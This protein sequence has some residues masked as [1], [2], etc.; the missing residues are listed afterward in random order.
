MTN[1]QDKLAGLSPARKAALF[2]SL[3]KKRQEGEAPARIGR[4]A[5]GSPAPLSF[6]QLRLWFLD[7]LTPGDPTYNLPS[8]T[9]IRGPLH[10]PA[11][12]HALAEVA[13]RHDA[14]RTTFALTGGEEPVQVIAPRFSPRLPVIDLRGLAADRRTA[15]LTLW[16]E[17]EASLPFD[18]ERGP[19]LR[20]CAFRQADDELIF[21]AVMHHS[22]SDGWS[23][24]VLM[25]EVGAL[26][27]A[28]LAGRP[29]PLAELPIQYADFAAW[30]RETL[31]GERLAA[32]IETWRRR[33]AEAPP[34]I[35]LPADRPRPPVKT[36]RG[37]GIDLS[38]PPRAAARLATLASRL[39]GT[40]F[41]AL[42]AA[43]NALLGRVSGATDLVV[44]TPIANRRLETSP[45]IG[46][47]VNTLA[48]RSDLSGDPAFE[49]LVARTREVALEAF[50]HQ[51][52]P[53][54]KLVEE[55]RPERD[56]S[57]TPVFQVMCALEN[58]PQE[59][60]P[61]TGNPDGLQL[62]TLAS[63]HTAAK[64]D[65]SMNATEFGEDLYGS[66]TGWSGIFELATVERLGRH[67]TALVAA[68][69][70]TP[71]ERISQL[72][73]LEP[74]EIAALTSGWSTPALPGAA[75][76]FV[77]VPERIAAWAVIDPE[78]PALRGAEG[79][80]SYGELR[81]RSLA[82]AHRLRA[83]GVGP[84][85]RVAVTG[86]RSASTVVAI[87]AVLEAGGAYVP[88]DPA[89][90][91]ERRAA[92]LAEAGCAVWLAAV[93]AEEE[94]RTDRSDEVEGLKLR[95]LAAGRPAPLA[96]VLPENAAYVLFTS[97]ST[98]TPKG[99][100][101]EHRQLVRYVEGA[102]TALGLPQGVP[103]VPGTRYALVST[104][105]AD[106]GHTS[107][108]PSLVTGGCLDVV[109]EAAI[110]DPVAF[111]RHLERCPADVLK[112]VPSHLAALLSGPRPAA[113][114]PRQRLI[115]GGE[116]TAPELARRL[117]ELAPDLAVFN[118][119]GPTE[120]TVGALAGP[121]AVPDGDAPIPLGRPLPGVQ[122]LL[123]GTAGEL[124]PE[125]VVGEIHIG[126]CGVARGYLGRPE[127]TAERFV[128]SPLAEGRLYRT[129]DLARL[130]PSGL[131]WLGR[132]DH[133][134]KIRGFRVEPG[135]VEAA[136]LRLDGVREAVVLVL[137]GSG[138]DDRR[139][140]GYAV[141]QEGAA[142]AAP[143]ATELRSALR[144]TLPEAM[145]PADVVILPRLPLTANGKVDRRALARTAPVVSTEPVRFAAPQGPAEEMLAGI[146]AEVLGDRLGEA[147][148]G[149]HDDFFALGGHSL[150]ATRVISRVREAFAVEVPLRA[151]FEAPTV[152][153]LAVRIGQEGI[154]RIG[155]IGR[156]DPRPSGAGDLPLSFAQQRL[157][158]LDRL[159]PD[160]PFYNVFNPLRLSGALDVAALRRAFRE[161]VLRHEG[162]RTTFPE[163][164]GRP[165][166]VI[167]P[168][169]EFLLPLV[170][171][172]GLTGNEGRSELTGLLRAE[173]LRPFQLARG[174]LF[175]ATLIRHA[176]REHT[177]LVNLH[178][179]ISDGWSMGILFAEI[180]A[181][182][183]AFCQGRPSPLPD[184]PIQYAD[185]AL[186][187]RDLLQG[188]RL[189]AELGYWRQQLAGLPESLELPTDH[190]RPVIDTFRGA[191]RTFTLPVE[192]V[193]ALA[194]LTR[195]RGATRS[196]TMLAAF[197]ALLGR[198]AGQEDLATGAV[199]ANRTRREVEGLIGFFVNTLVLRSNLSPTSGFAALL[200]RV[201]ETA[202]A[203]Y[204]HQDLPFE[205]LVEELQPERS[206]NR[207]PLIQVVFS[208]QNFPRSQAQVEGL[209][210]SVPDDVRV[211]TGTAKF[212][213][214]LFLFED[215]DRLQGALEFNRGIFEEA[216]VQR[217]LGG[218]ENLLTAAAADPEAPLTRL[219][220][221]SAAETHQLVREWNEP[222]T[223]WPATESLAA[224]FGTQARRTPDAIALTCG[225]GA[226]SYGA[227]DR[228]SRVLASR[229]RAQ[230]VG[231]E[232]RVG[233]S[234]ERSLELVVGL[235]G[236][237]QAGGAYVPLD[238]ASPR[239]RLAWMIEDAGIQIVVGTA[240]TTA[241]LPEAVQRILLDTG[242][243]PGEPFPGGDREPAVDGSSL[244]YVIYTSGSTGPPKGALVT[245]GNVSRL[246]A[247][248]AA[249]FGFDGRDVWT[250][251]H[252]YA[253]D[254]SVWEIWGA[255]LY[256]GRLVIVPW[257]VS[258]SPGPFLDL[259]VRER[260]T[261]L[262]QTP[263]AFAQ[264]AQADAERGGVA[265][266][267]RWVI[268]GG[269][270]LD[271]ASLG[272]WFA[273][274]GDAQPRL[275]NMYG[276]T[277]TTVHVTFRPL[278]AAEVRGERRSVIGV[279]IPDL[280]L[281]VMDPWLQPV[282]LGVPGELVVGGA[283][284]ARGYLGRPA[285]TA[286]RFVPD[287][288][289]GIPG[290]RLYRSGDRGRFLSRGG[291]EYWGRI[292]HQVKIRGFRIEPGEIE[293]RLSEHP[294]VLQA[295]VV[296]R[297]DR[298]AGGPGDRRLVAY[299]V[300]REAAVPETADDQVSGWGELFDDIY[301]DETAGS[302]PTFNII[303][304]NST[305]TGEPLPRAD[306]VE[307]LDDTIGRI[308]GLAPHRVLEIGCGTGMILWKI[309]PGA[310]LYTGTDVSARA[311]AYIE[312]RL[313]RV[314]GIDPARIRLV[315]GSAEDLA[316]LEAG[317]FDTAII[318]S[319]AQ[320]FPGADY[321]A[322][323]IARLVELVRPGGAIF[324]GDLRSLPLLEAFHTSL[325]VDQAAPEM[326]I[327][328]LRQ[329]IQIRRLQ[330]NELAI[331]P[332]FFT[333]L[334]HRLPGIGRVEIHAKRGRAHNELT[335]YRYQAVLRLGRPA[336]APEISWLDGT[337]QRLTLPA[338]RQLLT[339]GTP[340]ILGLRN[341]PNA[342]TAEAAAAVRL[343]RADDAAIRTAGELR[344]RAAEAAAGAIDPEELASLAQELGYAIE[345]GW[346]A[347]GEAG[348]FEAVLR[349]AGAAALPALAALLPEPEAGTAA[350]ALGLFTNNPLQGRFARRLAP[351][352]RAFLKDRLPD[353][354]V[355]AAFV[356]LDAFPL[357]ANGKVDRRRLP[358]PEETGDR[359]RPAVAAR[360]ATEATLLEI[361]KSLLG[362]ERI[363]IDDDFFALGGHSLLATQA[364]SRVRTAFGRELPLRT[365]FES[366]TVAQLAAWIGREEAG[367]DI[368]ETGSMG[369]IRPVPREG[370]LPLSFAQERLWFLQ[371]L[372]AR[373]LAYNESAAFRLEG[374]LDAAAFRG[375]LDELLR[376]HE[377]LRTTFPEV[378]GRAVQAIQAAVPF[379]I[380]AVDLSGLPLDR[381][382][383]E[384]RRLARAQAL[385]PFDLARGPLVRGLLVRLGA[386]DHAVLFSFHHIVFDGWSIGLF[387]GELSALYAARL[388]GRPSLLPPLEVQYADFAA[389]QRHR[390]QGETLAQ[391]VAWWREQLAGVA[392]LD[393]P[394]DRPRPALPQAVAGQ[395]ALV[396]SPA[397]TRAL[398]E[399][400]RSRGSTLFMTLLAAFQALLRRTTGQDDIA[401]GT[402]IAGRNRTEI[403]PLIGFFINMLVLRTR[404]A[405]DPRF[406]DLLEAV[407]QTALGA[408]AHQDLPFEKLVEEL[409][410]ARSLQ[411]T[412]LFQ[413]SFQVLNM[414]TAVLDLPGLTLHPFAFA[415]RST[416]FDLSL[417]WTDQG[418]RL[419]GL[420]GYDTDLFDATT[421]ERFLE[422]LHRLLEGAA[423][424]P[425]ARLSDLP[426]L[427]P[428]EQHQLAVEWND[429]AMHLPSEA[430]L[431]ELFEAQARRTPE[432]VAVVF[433][434]E[435]LRYRDLDARADRLARR[436]RRQGVGPGV[437]VGLCLERS[438]ELVVGLLGVL[439]AG[440]AYVP[441]DPAYPA[442]R[443]A[444]MADDA[445]VAVRL[446][447]A[448]ILELEEKDKKDGKDFKDG[449]DGG[450]EDLAY[451][452]Y[453]SG[454]T[455][456]P[457][458]AM[459]S[460]R[461]ICNRLLWLQSVDPLTPEDRVLQKTPFSFDVS[462]WE[463]FWP[464]ATGARLVLARPGGH[465]DP[466]Y[467]ARLLAEAG[468]TTVHFVP[469]LLAVFLETQDLAACT[470]LRRV[471]CSGE[472]LPAS[473]ERRFF[474]AFPAGAAPTLT[475]LYGPTEAAVEVTL[476]RCAADNPH[477]AVP[478]GRPAA[479][480][481][482]HVLDARLRPVPVG[483]PGE[484][485][486]GGVQLARGYHA[487]PELTAERFLPDPFG[488]GAR[489]YRTGDLVR[490][491]AG[492]EIV[493]LGRLDHQVKIRGVRIELGE[494]EAVLAGL[495]GVRQAVVVVYGDRLVAY[496]TGGAEEDGLRR[497][498]R[499][500][501]PEAMVPAAFVR[502]DA[503]PLLPSGK[504]D[505]KALPAPDRGPAPGYV[506][507]RTPEEGLLA[508]IWAELLGLEQVGAGDHFFERGG[509]SLLAVLLMARIEQRFGRAL[510]L[511]TL[512]AAPTLEA[513]AALLAQAEAPTP[514][515]PRPSLVLL[516]PRG[517]RKPF[518]CVHP[519]GGNVLCYLDLARHLGPDQ[520]FYALQSPPPGEG[521][522]TIEQMAARYL[523]ELREIQPEGPY[524]LGGWS[525]GGLVAFEMARQLAGEGEMPELV[526][527]I[528]TPPPAPGREPEG[529]TDDLRAAFARD[530]TRLPGHDAKT[531]PA[532]FEPLFATFVTNRRASRLYDPAPYPGRITLWLAEQ[533][534]ASLPFDLP[535]AWSR[536]APEGVE[537]STLPGD[538]YS[539]LRAPQVERLA[540][541]L[542][543]RLAPP[544][545]DLS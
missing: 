175:R 538:H 277:E 391:L 380:P 263:S 307:W 116:A 541:E 410:P 345:L 218:F 125:G 383:G 533:T 162:L 489:L 168:A 201:R 508:E 149:A 103:G 158:F 346:A 17:A 290:A 375:S 145:V 229:L 482:T 238:P 43:W 259:L 184:L 526:A 309:A 230:G 384:A 320:Y 252:S 18:L 14:L 39:H 192:L 409:R 371:R 115:L 419:H 388:A 84:E 61:V 285:L 129:G 435:E 513:L 537:A 322:A 127:L 456:R 362:V 91:E 93:E 494:I 347:P 318:N 143:T 490:R 468:I 40:A 59:T 458:G 164:A 332:A 213:L 474:A 28:F 444:F 237:L 416:K 210:L 33:L 5:P 23:M 305:Y 517:D 351:E 141:L 109:P 66:L 392:V 48:L 536:L 497:Q 174:P 284:L 45:L 10:V 373:S 453:T 448:E 486:L 76:G 495:E 15:E 122:V 403:E 281:L 111:A 469:S 199:I 324:L 13:G 177:L 288:C 271:P 470:A 399:L 150:L 26:Y 279:P 321:L 94:H 385:R 72:P 372:A 4:R 104:F 396:L 471:L 455:G 80:V 530:L 354:M 534:R 503:L 308:A 506:A 440:G 365:F 442:Q 397:L 445:G 275:V 194:E 44:G 519:V 293:A 269:E 171:L 112:I 331:D 265:T 381:R 446:G 198:Q 466:A 36:S 70:K 262:N 182:Y 438:F 214:T 264:L 421:V 34:A 353:Y 249:W 47:F 461:A 491:L 19:L 401:A 498:L 113:A 514:G 57:R 404:L 231:P 95:V 147:R 286:E 82:L 100:A 424:S 287:P 86:A 335:G 247:A 50:T 92:L 344:R 55:L 212:D 245:H 449:G 299:V 118:H 121:M 336:T 123:L 232:S 523:K 518:V 521:C 16:M 71:G 395:R 405:G 146:W 226:L 311:L 173:A 505:R 119:Y 310:E 225:D 427:T 350:Q 224:L 504:V 133:Q 197:Q 110:L 374:R 126:G 544:P 467:L 478:I 156:I 382:D 268:F 154:G 367:G 163:T 378:D 402:P 270:A 148:I 183:G 528:D 186:W 525:M 89:L 85:V 206:Q 243:A 540:Q 512:F 248:T 176:P 130:G 12:A 334:R 136:L 179:I 254:F 510:P 128:P 429:T 11:L 425:A 191:L 202:L 62:Q 37:V 298:S 276:I 302:D 31:R 314:P 193:R 8:A 235:L 529:S 221:L 250:L 90:P 98:G 363:G 69:L 389:W 358:A 52:L 447:R 487:R 326:P 524:R 328:R 215:G 407:R 53:F 273:R 327:D 79:E 454:S 500:R 185:F 242:D 260:V 155:S 465:Q 74:A 348:C 412:P 233:L 99:V 75:G 56:P 452:I 152:A 379:E 81:R 473:L 398:H 46:F 539:L 496:V 68:A 219:P 101:V 222:G 216:T 297:E 188:E 20:T 166:Q 195:R 313:G 464:L 87:V 355:P 477:G 476:W 415:V 394:T 393:L 209:V 356:L 408:Y 27:V 501:L 227:L 319:V 450:A 165:R 390:L 338:L 266:D 21:L 189:E 364:V 117:R 1:L 304:W 342:R 543:A 124:V 357:T 422:H 479:N 417:Q 83:A 255:L 366:P 283:G 339:H 460:H 499:E 200:G 9:R 439:K 157:W 42:L 169:A 431:H 315:H 492:G 515:A 181:L 25:R 208:Y 488:D 244:A 257:E 30:E 377:S 340:E 306:M 63:G 459:N 316:D 292:D 532:A 376:R 502:L 207:N 527:L 349:R 220:W 217:L 301:R 138:A 67:F 29:S 172:A 204:A 282:P 272:P 38:F 196:M 296:A 35:P 159:A 256:G 535:A 472:A 135:E 180:A 49:E 77:L 329:K 144:R 240:E 434:G 387:V 451:V 114:L 480:T 400:G 317:S 370:H 58:T 54:E 359:G 352:L 426:L 107:L 411:H 300:Q 131:V 106:L 280:S 337:A 420:L 234:G 303:G 65:L 323:V 24:G 153:E 241:A 96:P 522:D 531:D 520:P 325:E 493:Y 102:L 160:N 3:R 368:G 481:T 443:L 211:G 132:A 475:N 432:A 457:K 78:R 545:R 274:H 361:W 278:D 223:S 437:R 258:R 483:I 312:S 246:F 507:P 140:V 97:G 406:A 423:A 433:E 60:L 343:L 484:L 418:D 170:D 228:R 330:E 239:E 295:L 105:A 167:D 511:S 64:F 485:H 190:P 32:L 251:F 369:P 178:H 360:N 120:T 289:S 414:P 253:F 161:I 22:V 333:T 341:L 41:M 463:F 139:L 291:V 462:V 441:L 2:E 88:L 509:H 436:L 137:E 236:I 261:V 187:Q 142:T 542:R 7:R 73:I 267:L 205:R 134:V 428:A 203:A 516:Q 6:G 151:L 108:F 294:E 51:A 413:V 430:R 386:E